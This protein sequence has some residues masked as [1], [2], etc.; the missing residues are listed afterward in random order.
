MIRRYLDVLDAPTYTERVKYLNRSYEVRAGRAGSEIICA[1]YLDGEYL[2]ALAFMAAEIEPSRGA[3]ED[4]L[5]KALMDDAKARLTGNLT[6][7]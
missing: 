1:V 6:F 5:V 2:D 3:G 7:L 4:V